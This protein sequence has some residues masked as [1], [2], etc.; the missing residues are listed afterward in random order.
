MQSAVLKKYP[1]TN[2]VKGYFKLAS[3]F[4]LLVEALAKL[5]L[6]F[7]ECAEKLQDIYP[8]N[9]YGGTARCF[10]GMSILPFTSHSLH[11]SSITSADF[12]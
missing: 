10:G 8:T 1:F 12:H 4:E 3:T 7:G 11:I 5:N 9:K 6:H 2:R